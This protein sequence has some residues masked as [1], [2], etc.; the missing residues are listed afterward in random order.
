MKSL[1][2]EFMFV[3]DDDKYIT[4][5][6]NVGRFVDFGL[7]GV[8]VWVWFWFHIIGLVILVTNYLTCWFQNLKKK[9]IKSK[10][11]LEPKISLQAKMKHK[12]KSGPK[13]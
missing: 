12:T 5:N 3:K 8:G 7:G 4:R 6:L 11:E 13:T 9:I 2:F 1:R 10:L